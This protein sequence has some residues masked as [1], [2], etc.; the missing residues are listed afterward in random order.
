MEQATFSV[1]ILNSDDPIQ[2]T[3]YD[4]RWVSFSS[5]GP[6]D[7]G[8]DRLTISYKYEHPKLIQE[9][10]SDSKDCDGRY[11]REGVLE[12]AVPTDGGLPEWGEVESSQRDHSAEAMGY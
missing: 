7:E 5:G 11:E 4:G 1:Y 6:T 3:V 10:Y 2:I 9:Y 8:W 12:A